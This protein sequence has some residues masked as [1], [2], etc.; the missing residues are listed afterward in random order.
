L[1]LSKH[2]NKWFTYVNRLLT[3][4]LIRRTAAHSAYLDAEVISKDDLPLSALACLSSAP[5][6]IAEWNRRVEKFKMFR[7]SFHPS[8]AEALRVQPGPD[9]TGFER[10]SR[11]WSIAT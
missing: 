11:R 9:A 2:A 10:A 1:S 8:A 7:S 5:P 3:P 4:D 6:L